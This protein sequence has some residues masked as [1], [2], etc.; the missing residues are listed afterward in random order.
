MVPPNTP[1][2]SPTPTAA[3]G[4]PRALPL[5]RA[6][7]QLALV[8]STYHRPLDLVLHTYLQG[9]GGHDDEKTP[10]VDHLAGMFRTS[11]SSVQR[12][13]AR[14]RTE[15]GPHPAY[16][17][18][19]R[20]G[21]GRNSGTT[22][23][24][25]SV[26]GHAPRDLLND[27]TNGDLT[28]TDFRVWAAMDDRT[29]EQPFGQTP[30]RRRGRSDGLMLVT[31]RQLLTE[32]GSNAVANPRSSF[33]WDS[34]HRLEETGWLVLAEQ[35]GHEYQVAVP[36]IRLDREQRAEI[37][38]RLNAARPTAIPT[39]SENDRSTPV[40]NPHTTIHTRSGSDRSTRSG[41]DLTEVY[42]D[43]SSTQMLKK[44]SRAWGRSAQPSRHTAT[45]TAH[46]VHAGKTSALAAAVLAA[47]HHA[48][49]TR[50]RPVR[51]GLTIGPHP[52]P[53]P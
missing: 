49:A 18:R 14:L 11:V 19:R 10:G 37:A 25:H 24:Q 34:A 17:E 7:V 52:H 20:R 26:F 38:A 6:R 53:T 1:P 21:R 9:L 32:L 13:L 27:V 48:P 2:H 30:R 42:A 3:L 4:I 33:L 15:Q 43:S 22:V 5:R 51:L 12:A 46:A 45:V 47:T 36:T 28:P 41:S 35:P 40:D 29:H 16:L 31:M 8:F 39:R 44:I 23:H 50:A